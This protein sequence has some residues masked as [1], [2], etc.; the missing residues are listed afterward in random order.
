MSVTFI[1]V[2]IYTWRS[3]FLTLIMHSVKTLLKRR[4]SGVFLQER[5]PN[6]CFQMLER[7]IFLVILMGAFIHFIGSLEIPDIFPH[8]HLGNAP[9]RKKMCCVIVQLSFGVF[10]QRHSPITNKYAILTSSIYYFS[11][12]NTHFAVS[13]CE[14]HFVLAWTLITCAITTVWNVYYHLRNAQQQLSMLLFLHLKSNRL[15]ILVTFL[16]VRQM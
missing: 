4:V 5:I 6:H 12:E 14:S 11:I 3:L 1:A 16:W 8:K 10:S 9:M 15:P 2:N 13:K 7:Y